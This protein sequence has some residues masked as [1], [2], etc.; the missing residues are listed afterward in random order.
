[1]KIGLA[2]YRFENGGIEHNLSQIEKALA[3]ARGDVDLLCFGETFLQGFDALS[4]GYE[5][6]KD[7]AVSVDSEI[8]RRLCKLTLDY[9]TDLLLGYIERDGDGIYSSCAVIAGGEVVHDYRRI[10]KGW[11][12]YAIT[13]GHYREGAS[14]EGFSYRGVP[15]KIAL[16]GD[17]WDCPERF[18]TDGLLIWPV[19]VN[20]GLDE[21]SRQEGEYAAQAR[22]AAR[23]TLMVDPLSDDPVSHGGAF[24]FVDGRIEAK[25]PYDTEGILIV[26]VDEA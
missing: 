12:E 13:D 11:K 5:R 23:R 16:C 7:I 4:W 22:L 14:T 6:D 18:E 20:F 10:S 21:W 2:S 15:I 17:L 24:Y 9:G 3:R 8:M 26:Q 25:L 19:Y 1:M